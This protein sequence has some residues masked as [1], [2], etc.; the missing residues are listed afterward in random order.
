MN[1]I[2]DFKT[3]IPKPNKSNMNIPAF[4]FLGDGTI[5]VKMHFAYVSKSS[6]KEFCNN[7]RFLLICA[8]ERLFNIR[9]LN[10]SD[11]ENFNVFL[12]HD[13]DVVYEF[14]RKKNNMKG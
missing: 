6:I 13:D 14:R 2:I 1:N 7:N 8:C 4:T 12:D 9:R 10:M 11:Y 3:N 5:Q